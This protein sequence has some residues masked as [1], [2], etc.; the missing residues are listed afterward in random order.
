LPADR[1]AGVAGRL[2]PDG[3]DTEPETGETAVTLKTGDILNKLMGAGLMLA[4]VAFFAD[5]GHTA[6]FIIPG[7]LFGAGGFLLALKRDR[8]PTADLQLQ[9]RLEQL[10]ESLAGTQLELTAAQERLDRLSDERDFMRQLAAPAQRSA[11]T[12]PTPAE[13]PQP[14]LPEVPPHPRA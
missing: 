8:H 9:Q 4:S 13:V 5:I 2:R 14:R 10:A 6:A 12:P 3:H 11:A 1:C 7:L